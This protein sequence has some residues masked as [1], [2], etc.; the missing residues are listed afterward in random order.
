MKVP[1][2][3]KARAVL[4]AM[5]APS[6]SEAPVMLEPLD[7]FLVESSGPLARVDECEGPVAVREAVEMAGVRHPGRV[8][9][10]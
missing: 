10:R 7:E 1:A 9:P 6:M 2:L 5:E 3:S 4:E 8:T